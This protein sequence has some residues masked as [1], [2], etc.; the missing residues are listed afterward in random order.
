MQWLS[1]LERLFPSRLQCDVPLAEKTSL[2]VGG[3][4]QAY[5]EA[6]NP[7][8]LVRVAD[9]AFN[10]DVPLWT[11]GGGTNILVHDDGLGGIVLSTL[12]LTGLKWQ[13]VR[14]SIQ[15]IAESGVLLSRLVKLSG[16]MGWTGLEFATGIPGTVGGALAGNA[17][18]EGKGLCDLIEWVKTAEIGGGSRVRQKGEL[19]F[20]YRR[21][22]LS[23]DK[24]MILSCC[25]NLGQSTAEA[26]QSAMECF[27]QKRKMQPCRAK[28]AGCVFKNPDTGISAGKLLDLSGCKELRV[29]GAKVSGIH[30]N[31]LEVGRGAGARDLFTLITECRRRVYAQF[32]IWLEL[33]IRLFGGPWGK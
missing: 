24:T 30:A 3:P 32:G 26:V 5:L 17:G 22:C 12:G 13:T 7:D 21:S 15:I 19:S 2:G 1:K 4:A 6:E 23:D 8:D 25:L 18:T 29:G 20:S 28:T 11:I 10:E 14:D 33:E 16:Q 9:F 31:F 27:R